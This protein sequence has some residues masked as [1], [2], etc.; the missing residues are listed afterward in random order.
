MMGY[1]YQV[2]NDLYRY[3]E[4]LTEEELKQKVEY[5]L[6]HKNDFHED[7]WES[8]FEYQFGFEMLLPDV[9]VKIDF[10]MKK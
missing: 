1:I 10:R 5:S 2:N 3:P 7:S 6:K 9:G 4:K 8:T